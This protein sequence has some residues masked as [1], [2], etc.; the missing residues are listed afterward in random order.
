MELA[1]HAGIVMNTLDESIKKLDN[2]DSF[3]DYLHAVGMLHTKIPGF[4]RDYF[5]V[6][7]IIFLNFFSEFKELFKNAFYMWITVRIRIY[8]KIP[9]YFRSCKH[10][11]ITK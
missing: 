9:Y 4:R 2:V 7:K 8:N 10:I 5:W 3:M 1:Q 6:G 11:N